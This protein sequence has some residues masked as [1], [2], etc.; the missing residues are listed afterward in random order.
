MFNT[1]DIIISTE[2]TSHEQ[3]ALLERLIAMELADTFEGH[4]GDLAVESTSAVVM[5][6]GY[7]RVTLGTAI[8]T[9]LRAPRKGP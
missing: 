4:L 2:R 3:A 6:H 8:T 5:G 7:Y 9:Y 1:T